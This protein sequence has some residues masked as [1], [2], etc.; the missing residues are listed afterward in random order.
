M[1][2]KML[3]KLPAEMINQWAGGYTLDLYCDREH[4]GVDGY[5]QFY[6]NTFTACA[7]KARKAGWRL[8]AATRTATCPECNGLL[9]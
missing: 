6:G 3:R 9:R 8:Y 4:V 7:R 1:N 2:E 5:S